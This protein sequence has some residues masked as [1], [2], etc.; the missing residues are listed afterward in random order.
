MKHFTLDYLKNYYLKIV[1]LEAK[2]E[3]EMQKYEHFNVMQNFFSMN[4]ESLTKFKQFLKLLFHLLSNLL[5]I[6]LKSIASLML[7]AASTATLQITG[8]IMIAIGNS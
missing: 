3:I 6:A 2:G 8:A 1:R 5:K 4:L 7:L